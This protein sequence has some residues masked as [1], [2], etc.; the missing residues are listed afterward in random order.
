MS[1]LQLVLFTYKVTSGTCIFTIGDPAA[2]SIQRSLFV[3]CVVFWGQI[4]FIPKLLH[5]EW[6]LKGC[7][8]LVCNAAPLV[9]LFNSPLQQRVR[10]V[11][12]QSILTCSTFLQLQLVQNFAK[13]W[14]LKENGTLQYTVNSRFAHTS[15]IRT[16]AKSPAKNREQT[17]DSNKFPLLRTLVIKDTN[18][19]SRGC[20]Q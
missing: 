16:V 9:F 17:F 20:P 10:R 14:V 2:K 1:A 11:N 8:F 3:R 6:I 15:I 7:N 13:S 18:S 12:Y 5:Q 19:R 4:F